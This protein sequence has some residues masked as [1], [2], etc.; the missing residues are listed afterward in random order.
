MSDV[1]FKAEAPRGVS[2]IAGLV[3]VA[4]VLLAA[5]SPKAASDAAAIQQIMM[6]TWDRPESRL[7][8]DAIAS[9]GDTAVASWTQ[10]AMG[11]RALLERRNGAW[12][13]V[14][15]SGD[16]LKTE[17]GLKSVG[18]DPADARKLAGA[19]RRSEA[20]LAPD[21]LRKMTAFKGL[22]RMDEDDRNAPTAASGTSPVSERDHHGS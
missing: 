20:K 21:R 8:I 2:F 22:V 17:A 18:L 5:C 6:A 3:A 19:V 13:V 15:C 7:Q 16:A 10:G 4:V 11:G 12:Q 14:L 9:L 1:S